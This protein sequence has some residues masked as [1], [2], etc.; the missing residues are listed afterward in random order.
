MSY[1]LTGNLHKIYPTEEKSA[2]FQAREFVV[3]TEEN[4]PQYVKFQLTQDKCGLMDSYKEGEKIKVFFDLKGREWQ[5][6]YFT[7]L[8]AW[9]LEKV[10]SVAPTAPASGQDLPPSGFD[11]FEMPSEGGSPQ[12]FEDLPF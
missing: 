8:G 5:D 4:Y 12:D 6:K 1:E 10:E 7:N 3:V 2:S 9:K 11:S